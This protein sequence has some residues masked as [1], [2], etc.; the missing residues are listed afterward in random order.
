MNSRSIQLKK[1]CIEDIIFWAMIGFAFPL[2]I[3]TNLT[4]SGII[5]VYVTMFLYVFIGVF[6]LKTI[7]KKGKQEIKIVINYLALCVWYIITLFYRYFTGGAW[8]AS[9]LICFWTIIPVTIYILMLVQAL[10]CK[11]VCVRL[12]WAMTLL[13]FFSCIY[14]F[15]IVK[16]LRTDFLGNINMVVYYSVLG[17]F[18]YTFC[19]LKSDGKIN[20]L[21]YIFNMSYSISVVLFSGSRAGVLTGAFTVI[22]LIVIYAKNKKVMKSLG[23]VSL[24]AIVLLFLSL[25]T[26]FYWS[27]D[28]LFRGLNLRTLS[29]SV[30]IS[31]KDGKTEQEGGKTEQEKI[32]DVKLN[33]LIEEASVSG[34]T[35]QVMV[36]NDVGRIMMWENAIKE[37]KKAPLM[38]TGTVAVYRT[39][40]GGQL[41]HNVILEYWL[42]YGGVGFLLW[43][44]LAFQVLYRAFKKCL[45]DRKA[46]FLIL[47]YIVAAMMFSM[48]EPTMSNTFGAFLFWCGVG[49]F[50]MTEE[51]GIIGSVA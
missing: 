25:G 41:P 44:I 51:N 9:L 36:L 49:I 50:S 19:Y 32:T 1:I 21:V 13:N 30:D 29:E 17:M 37:V 8:S 38:G 26:N 46:L 31:K 35:E 15:L 47:A 7:I 18:I 22:M 28:M 43:I 11:K 4:N 33:Q 23:V 42:A 3:K 20:R 6:F 34:N 27:R 45:S 48:V 16:S 2:S 12:Y 5:N 40:E 14:S 10:D 39:A 24:I